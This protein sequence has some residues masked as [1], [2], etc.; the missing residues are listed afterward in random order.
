MP[1]RKKV[2]GNTELKEPVTQPEDN[3]SEVEYQNW[4]KS[5]TMA[6]TIDNRSMGLSLDRNTLFLGVL[7]STYMGCLANPNKRLSDGFTA[8][9]E[10]QAQYELDLIFDLTMKSWSSF[11]SKLQ[12]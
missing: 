10:K 2:N 12:E 6:P 1:P 5:T 3:Q 11:A 4:M 7:F 9:N 8:D